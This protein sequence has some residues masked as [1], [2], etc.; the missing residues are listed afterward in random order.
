MSLEST[1]LLQ[2][3]KE[4]E[5]Q[6]EDVPRVAEALRQAMNGY[7][8]GNYFRATLDAERHVRAMA[9]TTAHLKAQVVAADPLGAKVESLSELVLRAV[10]LIVLGDL[11]QLRDVTCSPSACGRSVA[12]FRGPLACMDDLAAVVCAELHRITRLWDGYRGVRGAERTAYRAALRSAHAA[13]RQLGRASDFARFLCEG[14]AR[15]EWPALCEVCAR[16]LAALTIDIDTDPDL[17]LLVLPEPLHDR[18]TAG[19]KP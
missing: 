1:S 9:R 10:R 6:V 2:R 11:I 13:M 18:R 7:D 8:V 4:L 12:L 15:T 3:L 5:Q 16:T 14:R 17:P 19:A